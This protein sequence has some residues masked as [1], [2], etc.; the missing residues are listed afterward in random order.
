MKDLDTTDQITVT[1]N[2]G[3]RDYGQRTQ[4]LRSC[5]IREIHRSKHCQQ[6]AGSL[7]PGPVVENHTD[8]N[9]GQYDNDI[10]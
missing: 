9:G 3:A 4:L 5:I 10:K 6:R 1:P 8:D 2:E 7:K